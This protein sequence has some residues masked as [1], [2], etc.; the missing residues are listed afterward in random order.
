MCSD[1]FR[2]LP[3]ARIQLSYLVTYLNTYLLTYV[4]TYLFTYLL[5]YFPTYIPTPLRTYLPTYLLIYLL[6]YLLTYLL[7]STI[8]YIV[9]P[10]RYHRSIRHNESY[11]AGTVFWARQRSSC[12]VIPANFLS[13]STVL[14]QLPNVCIFFL[15]QVEFIV[16]HLGELYLCGEHLA[17][18]S[19]FFTS[20]HCLF[21]VIIVIIIILHLYCAI[22][23]TILAVQRHTS[24]GIIML[25]ALLKKNKY[26]GSAI[27]NKINQ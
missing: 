11:P 16:V 22:S 13:S 14:L 12:H 8:N 25:K 15:Y 21:D 26:T 3:K 24:I 6:V 2:G 5:A 17:A 10:L 9:N 19:T 7:V 1:H 27:K 20:P 4:L 23:L 18:I